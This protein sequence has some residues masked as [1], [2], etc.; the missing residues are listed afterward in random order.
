VLDPEM[1]VKRRL[2]LADDA[3]LIRPLASRRPLGVES[4]GSVPSVLP[5]F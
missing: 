3:T 5:V 2:A 1:P 4:V